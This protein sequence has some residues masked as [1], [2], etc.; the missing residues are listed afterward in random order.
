MTNVYFR[1]EAFKFDLKASIFYIV[2]DGCI[3]DKDIRI[4]LFG[5]FV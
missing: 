3:F 5:I 2:K 4:D 1:M